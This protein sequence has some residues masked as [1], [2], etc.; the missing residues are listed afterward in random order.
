MKL[1]LETTTNHVSQDV[2]RE[3]E[4][5]ILSDASNEAVEVRNG[6]L[7]RGLF[8]IFRTLPFR[9]CLALRGE[10]DYFAVLMGMGYFGKCLPHF[11]RARRRYIYLFDAW[12]HHH[13]LIEKAVRVCRL[14][15]VFLSSSQ[16]VKDFQKRKLT[17]SC[18]WIPEGIDVHQYSFNP[19]CEKDIDVLQFG[20][21]WDW[22]HQEIKDALIQSKK[23]YVFHLGGGRFVFKTRQDF[24]QGLARSKISICIPSNIGRPNFEDNYSTMTNR[25]LQSMA[26]KCLIVGFMP[27]EMKELFAYNPIIE[28]DRS[29]PSGQLLE[30]L[31]N[32]QKYEPLVEKNYEVVCREH[33]WAKRWEIIQENIKNSVDLNTGK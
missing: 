33:T 26:A 10:A 12:K 25:Y 20:R 29:D 16:A 11:L 15:G 1:L 31:A 18:Q 23:K 14:D 3:F 32:F 22:Y 13:D 21:L 6:L 4:Q 7:S 24:I 9:K 17:V 8:K 30:I 5:V 19:Y 2:L 28:I 27:D